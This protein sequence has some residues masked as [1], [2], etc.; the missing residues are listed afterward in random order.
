MTISTKLKISKHALEKQQLLKSNTLWK[1]GQ[2]NDIWED[3][4]ELK[5]KN[6]RAVIDR[7][8]QSKKR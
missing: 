3:R 7:Q 8:E 5:S 1:I 4:L 2:P 6:S